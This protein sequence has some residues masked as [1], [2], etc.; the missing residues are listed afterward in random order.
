MVAGSFEI[1]K[2]PGAFTFS[3]NKYGNLVSRIHRL[4]FEAYKKM[5]IDHTINSLYFGDLDFAYLR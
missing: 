1:G 3:F 4:N 2:T 5:D